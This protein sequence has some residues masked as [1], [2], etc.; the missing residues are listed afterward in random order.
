M[1]SL[2]RADDRFATPLTVI[3]GGSGQFRGV[4]TEPSQGEVPS[5]QFNLPR[6]LLRVDA[7]TPIAAGMVV[8][9][10]DGTVF[11]IG[12][13]GDSETSHGPAFRSFRLFEASQKFSWKRRGKVT[14]TRTGLTKDSVLADQPEIWGVYEPSPEMFDRQMRTSFE[15]GR[16]ITNADVQRDDVVNGMKVS[17]VDIQLGL[18]LCQLG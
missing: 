13:H 12:Q 9:S 17:R 4:I 6:R 15:S 14:D 10:H 8:R 5:Y 16:F 3:E 7:A 2:P 1:P 11:M 18:R